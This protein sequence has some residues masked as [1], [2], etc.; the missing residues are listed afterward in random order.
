MLIGVAVL[1]IIIIGIFTFVRRAK[2]RGA[3]ISI[4]VVLLALT[5]Y[6]IATNHRNHYGMHV[7]VD[8]SGS[9][10]YSPI[11]SRSHVLLYDDGTP[12]KRRRV[13]YFKQY[14]GQKNISKT[15]P[16]AARTNI[17]LTNRPALLVT[18]TGYRLYNS[19][20]SQY[21][22]NFSNNANTVDHKSYYFYLNADWITMS[23]DEAQKQRLLDDNTRQQLQNARVAN[24]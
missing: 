9:M 20:T 2:Y 22:F 18:K 8:S 24:Y 7:F 19:P 5:S 15:A 23:I 21:W 3:V 11:A 13:Y 12:T 4:S 16:D 14:A 10:L 6:L 1:L 17:I